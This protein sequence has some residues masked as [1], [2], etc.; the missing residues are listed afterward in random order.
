MYMHVSTHL[1]QFIN[2]EDGRYVGAVCA[3]PRGAAGIG[4]P[5][6]LAKFLKNSI[7]L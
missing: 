1:Q 4:K 2:L 7:D 3:L 6:I 5:L